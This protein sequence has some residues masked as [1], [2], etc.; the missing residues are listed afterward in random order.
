L[1]NAVP[2]I[3]LCAFGFFTPTLMGSLA[4]GAGLGI[5]TFGIGYMF[6]HD[7]LVHK[8]FPGESPSSAQPPSAR[9]HYGISVMFAAKAVAAG[10][11]G[12]VAGSGCALGVPTS[13]PIQPHAHCTTP[14]PQLVPSPSCRR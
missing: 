4:F 12:V 13:A 9:R 7:G 8:R 2:A 1:V 5:T 14:V 6:I 10:G 11:S 3:G